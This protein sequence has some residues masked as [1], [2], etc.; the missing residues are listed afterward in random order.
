[1]S[2][3]NAPSPSAF[4][5][6]FDVDYEDVWER[7]VDG[8]TIAFSLRSSNDDIRDKQIGLFDNNDNDVCHGTS[9]FGPASYNLQVADEEEGFNLITI[10]KHDTLYGFCMFGGDHMTVIVNTICTAESSFEGTGRFLLALVTK[11]AHACTNADV[12]VISE[13]LPKA[14]PFYEKLGFEE[15]DYTVDMKMSLEDESDG[16]HFAPMEEMLE[17]ERERLKNQ[18]KFKLLQNRV[19]TMGH[20]GKLSQLPRDTL[21][22]ILK[23]KDQLLL[24]VV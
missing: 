20:I 4:L 14:K 12:L 22:M 16:V 8:W 11:Y 3:P 9:I 13:P 10:S 1:M 5:P 24:L 2:R 15:C 18:W 19:E 6:L 17:A 23:S 7:D 21:D